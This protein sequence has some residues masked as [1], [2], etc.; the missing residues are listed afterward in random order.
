MADYT[1]VLTTIDPTESIQHGTNWVF[2]RWHWGTSTLAAW[3]TVPKGTNP[4]E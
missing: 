2:R 1:G 4:T 3:P